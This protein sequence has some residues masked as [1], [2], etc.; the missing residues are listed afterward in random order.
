MWILIGWKPCFYNSM[1]TWKNPR[2][3]NF[4]F[5]KRS[6]PSFMV[7]AI[8]DGL[9]NPWWTLLSLVVFAITD[10]LSFLMDFAIPDSFSIT[11]GLCYPWWSLSSLMVFAIPDGLCY[12]W[13][14]LLSLTVF[15]IPDGLCYTHTTLT[16]WSWINKKDTK[17]FSYL[18]TFYYRPNNIDFLSTQYDIYFSH[19]HCEFKVVTL[20][21]FFVLRFTLLR[22][23]FNLSRGIVQAELTA[24]TFGTK[25]NQPKSAIG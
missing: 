6:L 16:Q 5:R 21:H 1:E 22:I 8:P 13:W 17:I 3:S 23:G 10:G 11:D 24:I 4:P 19:V 2:H 14:S 12:P 15:A 18:F 9:C 7:F 20:L 25:N